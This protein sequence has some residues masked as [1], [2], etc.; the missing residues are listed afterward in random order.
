MPLKSISFI[1]VISIALT[2]T[3]ASCS[4]SSTPISVISVVSPSPTAIP[5]AITSPTSPTATP[6]LTNTP[7][8]TNTLTSTSTFINTYTNT[9]TPT[10]TATNTITNSSTISYTP[11]NT[12]TYT[13]SSTPTNSPTITS[14]PTSV[15][16]YQEKWSDNFNG[17]SGVACSGASVFVADNNTNGAIKTFNFTGSIGPT[18]SVPAPKVGLPTGLATDINGN[19]YMADSQ[20]NV[21]REYN[22]SAT[23]IATYVQGNAGNIATFNQPC[24]VAVDSSGTTIYVADSGNNQIQKLIIQVT[25]AATPGNTP[26]T[27]ITQSQWGNGTLSFPEGITATTTNVYV[28]DTFNNQ[29]DSFDLNGNTQIKWGGSGAGVSQFSGPIGIA[30]C[31]TGTYIGKLFVADYGNN[32]IEVLDALNNGN[33]FSQ[34]GS[35]SGTGNGILKGPQGVAVEGVS[36]FVTDSNDN[37]IQV[38]K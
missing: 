11:T 8:P 25:P 31:N 35:S 26:V 27:V 1:L 34:F 23:P 18:W 7:L 14:T 36:I 19:V 15:Y 13:I 9:N 4:N 16:Q 29:V 38:F 20:N 22:S 5:T 2:I 3:M 21:I 30:Y 32:R 17:P 6:T 28:S 33:Y 10:N 37:Q 24:G 12:P